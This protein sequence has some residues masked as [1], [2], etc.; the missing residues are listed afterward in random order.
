M[1]WQKVTKTWMN[2]QKERN[3]HSTLAARWISKSISSLITTQSELFVPSLKARVSAA[4]LHICFVMFT[5]CLLSLRFE[6]K[7]CKLHFHIFLLISL[8]KMAVFLITCRDKL[9]DDCNIKSTTLTYFSC[10]I[11]PQIHIHKG[12]TNFPLITQKVW[13]TLCVR[14]SYPYSLLTVVYIDFFILIKTKGTCCHR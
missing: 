2:Y 11:L 4:P 7:A 9:Y 3:C 12:K 14:I 1:E 13:Q 10:L 8:C 6:Q 5:L